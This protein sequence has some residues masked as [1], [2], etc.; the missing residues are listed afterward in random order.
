[1][2]DTK[3]IAVLGLGAMGSRMAKRLVD[4]GYHVRVY[5]RSPAAAAPLVAEGAE[6]APTPRDA[7][8]GRDVVLGCVRD[9]EASRAIWLSDETGALAAMKAGSIVLESSTLTPAFV[10]ELSAAAAKR[11]LTFLDAPV[12]GTRPH[13][14]AGQLTFLVGGEGDAL[15][16]VRPMLGAL[17]SSIHHV[18][19]S[20][21]GATLK[22][23]VNALFATQVAAMA[24]LLALAQASELDPHATLE[25]LGALPVTS[26]AAKGAG[27]LM[28]QQKHRPMFPVE[29]VV[30][31]LGYAEA[32]AHEATAEVP[33]TSAVRQL[34]GR[35]Q[36]SGAGGLNLTAVARLF[37]G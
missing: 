24:E 35:S 14:E 5:N 2:K 28:L 25:I 8:R 27:S 22:L 16:R 37:D 6:Q 1:V 23:L 7:V 12:V 11:S 36:A 34:F 19:G 3:K 13:A 30:K 4:A 29:L 32:M 9:D 26:A 21:T 31:D 10:G 33:I 15:E 20:G 17:G 18:G